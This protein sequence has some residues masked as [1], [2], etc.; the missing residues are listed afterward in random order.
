M[1]NLSVAYFFRLALRRLWVLILAGIV[2]A[3]IAFCYC[4]FFTAPSYTASAAVVLN[5]T[6]RSAVVTTD[7]VTGS[8]IIGEVGTSLTGTVLDILKT[9]DIYRQVSEKLGGEYTWWSIRSGISI[10]KRSE[11]SLFVDIRYTATSEKRRLRL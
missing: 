5:S 8:A 7:E 1:A 6:S 3:A 9:S 11:D 10:T 2:C 4:R